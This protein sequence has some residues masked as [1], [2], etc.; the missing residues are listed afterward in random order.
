MIKKFNFSTIYDLQN[1]SR[2]SFYRKFL[3]K[4]YKWSSAETILKKINKKEVINENSVLDRFKFQL[5]NSNIKTNFT[6]KPD[7]SWACANVD[8]T[9]NKYFGK[10]FIIIFP[11][12]SPS[13]P[14]K[15]WPYYIFA[16]SALYNQVCNNAML[17]FCNNPTLS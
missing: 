1:S 17:L 14:H 4:N 13:L 3:L 16:L 6:L 10:N 8:S 7:F 2:T 11:F 15:K 5:D 9:I 12:C